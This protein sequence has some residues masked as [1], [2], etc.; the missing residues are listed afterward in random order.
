MSSSPHS[1]NGSGVGGSGAP[2]PGSHIG[3]GGSGGSGDGSGDGSGSE[4]GIGSGSGSGSGS[5]K[6]S[7]TSAPHSGSLLWSLPSKIFHGFD[8]P[9]SPWPLL[10]DSY[11][12]MLFLRFCF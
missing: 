11:L 8:S 10:D 3:S 2:G 1:G 6:I 5:S 12:F 9:V 4:S 7:G